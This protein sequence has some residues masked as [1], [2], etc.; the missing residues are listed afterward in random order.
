VRRPDGQDEHKPFIVGR[1][2]GK[3]PDGGKKRKGEETVSII[4]KQN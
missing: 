1:G 2:R 3:G 4:Q